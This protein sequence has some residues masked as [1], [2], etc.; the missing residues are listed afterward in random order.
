[1]KIKG[2]EYAGHA[3]KGHWN[4]DVWI[5][6]DEYTYR[7]AMAALKERGRKEAAR[8]LI[9]NVLPART[10]DGYQYTYAR[11]YAALDQE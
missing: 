5:N 9:T 2:Q 1:M 3:S 8:W 11:V 7:V 4:V 10:P 6:N